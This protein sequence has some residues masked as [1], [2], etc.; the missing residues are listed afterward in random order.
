MKIK[1][2]KFGDYHSWDDL[3]LILGSKEIESPE[4]KTM[5]IDIPG[6][7]GSLDLTEYFGEVN[8]KNRKLS[9][10]F[11][12]IVPQNEFLEL[13]SEIQNLLN[14]QK[15]QIIIDDDPD[16]YY[17]GRIS[18]SPWKVNKSVGELTI[19][20]DCEPFKYKLNKTII[21]QAVT[22][23]KEIVLNNLRKRV[24][25]LVIVDSQMSIQFGN[26]TFTV[27]AGTYTFPELYL[28]PGKNVLTVTGTGNI[29]FEYQE[30]GL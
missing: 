13:F 14:G 28:K 7:D 10:V 11:S 24:N 15:L 26:N 12:T 21:K 18:I 1:G 20:A 4:P 29:T 5:Y 22:G 16:F 27:S 17:I 9:F 3:S 30:G 2:V 6:A 25:P 19:E 8:Y 23:S